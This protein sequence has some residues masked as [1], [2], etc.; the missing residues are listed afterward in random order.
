M[1]T[2]IWAAPIFGSAGFEQ[3]N[4]FTGY[5]NASLP[6]HHIGG[7]GEAGFDL[8]WN[9][10]PGWLAAYN[11]PPG[12]NG[13]VAVD[14][15]P[16]NNIAG[17]RNSYGLGGPGAVYARTGASWKA[18]PGSGYGLNSTVTSVVFVM[19]NGSQLSLTD[20]ASNGAPEPVPFNSC[21]GG[22][23]GSWDAG[24][25]TSFRSTDNSQIQFNASSNVLESI[26]SHGY[27]AATVSGA[28]IL[29]NGITYTIVNSHV[30]KIED[31]NGNVISLAY[32]PDTF[33]QNIDWN[34]AVTALSQITDSLNRVTNINYSDPNCGGCLTITYPGAGGASREVQVITGPL[35]NNYSSG[36]SP[37]TIGALFPLP[38]RP[39]APTT[40]PPSP[41]PSIFPMEANTPF[42]TTVG[43][44]WRV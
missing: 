36:S 22:G 40:I 32:Y 23:P 37:M 8:V 35:A 26:G 39:P 6:L 42:N 43:A 2:G 13:L 25:G 20:T 41:A 30:C 28:L 15:F 34:L 31:R 27:G 21:A 11:G 24:R 29:P 3:Y 9:L 1:P 5:L 4:S 12:P 7:R 16:S 38:A 44:S 17:A 10:Q 33:F 18:C 19:P 14:P